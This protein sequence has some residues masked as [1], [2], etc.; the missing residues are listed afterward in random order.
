MEATVALETADGHNFCAGVWIGSQQ[1]LTAAHCVLDRDDGVTVDS[2]EKIK[3]YDGKTFDALVLRADVRAD[4]ALLQALKVTHGGVHV[5][6][7][8]HIGEPVQIVGHPSGDDWVW[9]QGYI[10]Q[11]DSHESPNEGSSDKYKVLRIQA[12]IWYGNSGGGCFD[13]GGH[14]VGIASTRSLRVPDVGYFVSP[15]EIHA[16]LKV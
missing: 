4:L 13:A 7:Q 6:T 5:A 1:I 12:P 14:L 8:W 3:D 11:F 16:F 10:S 2:S 9:T 15:D